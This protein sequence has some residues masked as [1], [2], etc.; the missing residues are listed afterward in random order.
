MFNGW[1]REEGYRIGCCPR[2]WIIATNASAI[3]KSLQLCP[4]LCDPIDGSPPGSLSLGFSRQEH[5]SGLPFPSPMS[6][7][8]F[9]TLKGADIP[10]ALLHSSLKLVLWYQVYCG[11][12]QWNP[13]KTLGFL[14]L[15]GKRIRISHRLEVTEQATDW[16]PR[17]LSGKQTP[18]QCRRHKGRRFDPRV[19][20]I[21][22]RRRWQPT[23]VF[24]SGESHGWRI[25][26]G[27][28]Q[29]I[30]LQREGHDWSD[31]AGKQA[32]MDWKQGRK[33]TGQPW[34]SY[35]PG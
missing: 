8:L 34:L 24:L 5:W 33:L 27:C 22:W 17:W 32:G 7:G 15:G 23:P 19:G 21:P 9:E 28:I 18:C 4:T 6:T 29:S 13:M 26:A 25:L 31:W 16:F 11:L 20:R 1:G 10:P 30:G 14:E 2:S 12:Y 3:A 35:D